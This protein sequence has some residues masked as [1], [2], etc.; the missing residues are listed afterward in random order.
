MKV[1]GEYVS[2][3][4]GRVSQFESRL[5]L[6]LKTKHRVRKGQTLMKIAKLYNT[7]AKAI[8]KFNAISN[9]QRIRAGQL[10]KIPEG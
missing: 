3:D 8:V 7:S 4:G 6:F 2:L 1:P 10:L 5:P 9:P